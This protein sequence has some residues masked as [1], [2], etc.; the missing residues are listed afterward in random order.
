[1]KKIIRTVIH[2]NDWTNPFDRSH[3]TKY[4]AD[5]EM[6]NEET[7]RWENLPNFPTDSRLPELRKQ[8]WFNAIG[9]LIDS[10]N[11]LRELKSEMTIRSP[12]INYRGSV[13]IY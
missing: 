4:F 3:E 10:G 11:N 12:L 9:E 8:T 2:A 1:M 6:F 7:N 13:V 5:R